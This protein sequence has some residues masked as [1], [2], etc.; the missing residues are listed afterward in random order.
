M[1]SSATLTRPTEGTT[2]VTFMSP[3]YRDPIVDAR[4]FLQHAGRLSYESARPGEWLHGFRENAV[5]ARRAL[6]LHILQAEREDSEI[7]RLQEQQPRLQPQARRHLAEHDDILRQVHELASTAVASDHADI[8][9]MVDL[10]EHARL[11]EMALA[12]HHERYVGLV[13]E[14]ENREIGGEAG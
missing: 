11:A 14:A 7:N 6:A 4:R 12:R 3:A 1:N 10:S 13:Y 5:A 8:W 2:A 9:R